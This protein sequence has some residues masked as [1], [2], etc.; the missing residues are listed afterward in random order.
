MIDAFVESGALPAKV[1]DFFVNSILALL[2]N[3]EPVIIRVED[4]AQK[5]EQLPPMDETA[6]KQKLNEIIAAY[7]KGKDAS[8]LR[9]VVKSKESEE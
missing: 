8:T 9:I 6:F 1:D 5:L 2:K 4:L 7:T 3:Y